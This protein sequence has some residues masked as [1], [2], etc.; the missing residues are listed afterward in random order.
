MPFECLRNRKNAGCSCPDQTRR[1]RSLKTRPVSYGVAY[2]VVISTV[3]TLFFVSCIFFPHVT[4]VIAN[5]YS[6]AEYLSST[7]HFSHKIMNTFTNIS[8]SPIQ[9]PKESLSDHETNK[10][11]TIIARCSDKPVS[12]VNPYHIMKLS[13]S[14]L[15][16]GLLSYFSSS[17]LAKNTPIN[18]VKKGL[19]GEKDASSQ[20]VSSRL[21]SIDSGANML[22]SED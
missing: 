22:Q 19:R 13:Y 11:T 17:A 16:F 5:H 12:T 21:F 18:R 14:V 6:R 2:Q 1:D 20:N 4:W 10:P 7:R 8:I 3:M 9:S 15:S